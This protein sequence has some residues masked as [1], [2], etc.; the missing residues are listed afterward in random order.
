MVDTAQQRQSLLE[1]ERS[2]QPCRSHVPVLTLSRNTG[3]TY[4]GVNSLIP[5]TRNPRVLEPN[6]VFSRILEAYERGHTPNP[7]IM[8]N[9]HI[10]FSALHH[11]C[12][13][14]LEVDTIATGHY[15]RV[16][17]SGTGSEQLSL[18][19]SPPPLSLSLSLSLSAEV[20]LKT[21]VDSSKDQTYFL[22]QVPQVCHLSP[23]LS[24]TVSGV[25]MCAELS[26]Q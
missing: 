14:H 7:D 10:K 23:S 19:P 8:C 17:K 16:E 20:R 2:V 25:R 4:S 5:V 3:M 26:G 22:S 18:P 6:C 9:R 13:G 21:A 1:S 15:A 12:R 11:Y 24:L